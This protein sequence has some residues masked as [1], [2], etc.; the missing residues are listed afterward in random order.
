M[1]EFIQ[2]QMPG[3]AISESEF[4]NGNWT[5]KLTDL[6][7][8]APAKRNITNGAEQISFDAPP[9]RNHRLVQAGVHHTRSPD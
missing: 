3:I 8:L 9:E 7:D 6:L 4:N 1:V 2:R 5:A